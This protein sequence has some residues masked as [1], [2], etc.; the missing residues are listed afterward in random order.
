MKKYLLI[1]ITIVFIIPIGI[2][3]ST[4][5][6]KKIKILIDNN[7]IEYI[8]K[9]ES[10]IKY[11]YCSLLNST[12]EEQDNT[13]NEVKNRKFSGNFKTEEGK[14]QISCIDNKG[15]NYL[16]DIIYTNNH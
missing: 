13:L 12:K 1:L 8:G 15:I 14:Y 7:S 11:I 6:N 16:T 3:A 4:K 10:N 9:T 5:N 2:N